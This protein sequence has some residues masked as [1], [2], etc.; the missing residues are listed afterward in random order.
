MSIDN[1]D[2]LDLIK[3]RLAEAKDTKLMWNF[4]FLMA[5]I[6]LQSIEYIIQCFIL[7]WH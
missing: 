6:G 5:G 2:R 1:Q 4:L 7:S 3:Y